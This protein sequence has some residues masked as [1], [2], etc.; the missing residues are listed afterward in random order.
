MSKKGLVRSPL[1]QCALCE[2]WV[3]DDEEGEGGNSKRVYVISQGVCAVANE[4]CGP[5]KQVESDPW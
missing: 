1:G 5:L 3:V 2:V 4:G